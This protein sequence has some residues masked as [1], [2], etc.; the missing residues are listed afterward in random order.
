VN[1]SELKELVESIYSI[2]GISCFIKDDNGETIVL[3]KYNK[4][5]EK[6]HR[7]SCA[8][9]LRQCE[10]EENI[11]QRIENGEEYAIYRCKNNLIYMGTPI[12][13]NDN[14]KA[15][16]FAGQVFSKEPNIEECFKIQEKN[17]DFDEEEYIKNIKEIPI[18]SEK[19]VEEIINLLCKIAKIL[20][21]FGRRH[22]KEL[23]TN[24]KLSES[25]IELSNVH[26]QLS[27]AEQELRHQYEEMERMAYY[28]SVTNLPNWNLF[29]KKLSDHISNSPEKFAV[30]KVDLDNFKNVNDTYG[31]EYG[32][33]LLKNMGES[34]QKELGKDFV[35]ARINGDKF[36]IL[37]PKI[38]NKLDAKNTAEKLFDTLNGLWEIDEKEFF[39]SVSI[40][41]SIYPDDGKDFDG[42][43]SSADIAVNK[44]K[45]SGKN[46]YKF[47]ESSMHDEIMKKTELEKQ[48]RKAIKDDEFLLYYQPQVNVENRKIVSFEA[49][50]RW[51][52]EKFGWISPAEFIGLAEETG[53]I[54]PIGEWVLRTACLQ[55]KEWKEKGYV[56]DFISVNVSAVQ[57]QKSD[58]VNMVK[59]VLKETG[60]K[61]QSLEIEITESVMMES[62]D[63]NLNA[64]NELR[65][66]GFRVALDDFGTGYS[67]LNYLKNLPI[68]TLKI[69][70]TFIDGLCKNSY[71]EIITEQIIKLAHKMDLEVVAEGV[72]LE[73]QLKSLEGKHCN[74]IQGYYFA[75][76]LPPEEIGSFIQSSGL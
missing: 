18:I 34:M 61:P 44:A 37:Q 39:A 48:L 22:L 57:L 42:I 68:N 67:S 40:G 25:Y 51:K 28:D 54:I 43:L 19:R 65:S 33:K 75:K 59:K 64:L 53:L 17:F 13:I 70:K 46:L 8:I 63:L 4:I 7:D 38:N 6:L 69:D 76:P 24:K 36:L 47:F 50:I 30:F 12:V 5:C 41:I 31:H 21:E 56:Y 45:D 23:E 32:D 71:E 1:I 10:A 52:N 73:E 2:T 55:N 49:L 3:T 29:S 26:Q 15:I 16:L 60:T 9:R 74:K 14:Y 66:M 72:E 62:L 27:I 20:G 11:F 35:V 58:F